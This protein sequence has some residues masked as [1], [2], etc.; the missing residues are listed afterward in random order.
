M[1]KIT[2]LLIAGMT[3]LT[4]TTAAQAADKNFNGAYA[5]AELGYN[6]FDFADDY[7]EDGVYYGGFVGYRMQMD[8][9][10]VIGLEG[11]FG[12]SSATTDLG[13]AGA[14]ID[15]GRQLGVDATLGYALGADK[16]ILAFALVG[17]TNTKISGTAANVNTSATGD[18]VRFG[19]GGEYALTE[20]ISLR[21]T[22]A[23]ANYE[24]DANDLQLN[25]GVLFR[26]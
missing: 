22:G 19:L 2:S 13:F 4:M 8:S 23:Y 6:S 10:L 9:D 7:R 15:A 5:G 17:Y 11:R 14:E 16:N 21:A 18:G 3:A 24:G 20:N 12:D 1:K 26:F 25:A